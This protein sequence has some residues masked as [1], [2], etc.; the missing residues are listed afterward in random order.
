VE[1]DQ[2]AREKAG[3]GVI[4]SGTHQRFQPAWVQLGVVVEEYHVL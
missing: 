1:V 4:L 3:L 2:L